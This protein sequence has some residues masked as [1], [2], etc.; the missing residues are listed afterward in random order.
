M[1]Y[2]LPLIQGLGKIPKSLKGGSLIMK[3]MFAIF[4]AMLFVVSLSFAVSGCKKSEE[5]AT[6]VKEATKEAA[7]DVKDATKDA[8]AK[9]KD[10]TKEAA[11]EVKDATTKLKDAA[12]E[13]TK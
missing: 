8:A 11:T 5:A 2:K 6:K 3:K 1:A 10:A 9:V 4:I 7:T 13:A 12:K